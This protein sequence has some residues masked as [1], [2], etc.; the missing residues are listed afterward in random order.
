MIV[1]YINHI[2]VQKNKLKIV[3]IM[4]INDFHD[5]IE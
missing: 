4:I 1:S 2:S 5:C 3:N